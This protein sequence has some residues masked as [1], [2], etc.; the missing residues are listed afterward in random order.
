MTTVAGRAPATRSP[1]LR[2]R[3]SAHAPGLAVIVGVALVTLRRVVFT[4]G[5]PAGTDLFGF[6]SRAGQNA[7][8]ARIVD[9]WNPGSFGARRVFTF[10]NVL[11]LVTMA[12]RDPV[13]TVKLFVALTF[14]GS[15][16][17]AYALAWSWF[18][19]RPAA[20]AAGL[21]Y[22]MSQ[23]VLTR[24]G[25]GLLNVE[26]IIALA[27][28]V[29]LAW[30]ACLERFSV[31][32][33]IG[34]TLALGA[35]FLV[36]A[37]LMLYLAPF[38]VI[39]AVVVMAM[40]PGRR[41]LLANGGRTLAIAIP[42]V[43]AL[44]AAWLAPALTGQRAQYQTLSQIFSTSELSSRS[45]DLY[46]SLVG[47]GREIGY[48]GF[49]GTETWFSYPGLP[50][51]AY[52]AFAT[53]VPA[54]ALS[55]L[56]WRRDLRTVFLALSAVAAT[57]AAPGTRAPLGSVYTWLIRH[58][59]VVGNLRDPNRWLIVQALA[60]ALLAGLA[61]D[62]LAEGAPRWLAAARRRVGPSPRGEWSART[63]RVLRASSGTAL[64]LAALVPVAPTIV[65]GLRT[66]HV[67]AGQGQLLGA[68]SASAGPAGSVATVPFDQDYR[69]VV[70]GTY[71]GYEHDLGY[72]SSLYTRRGEVGDGSWNQRSANLVAY[73]ASLLD[74]GDPAFA[75]ILA[76]LGVRYLT[77]FAYPL[78]VPQLLSGSVGPYTQQAHVATMAGLTRIAARGAGS[79]YAITGASSPLSFRSSVAVVLGGS[80]GLA[81]LADWP[82]VRLSDWA[83]FSADD[84][85][86][87]QG[88][89]ALLSLIRRADLV[90]LAD[91]RPVDIAVEGTAPLATV[92][93]IT[94][95]PQLDRQAT[96]VP[97]DQSAQRGSLYDFANPVLQPGLTASSS[98]VAVARGQSAAV[99]VRVLASAQAA[100]VR[101]SVDGRAVGSVTPVTLGPGGFEWIGLGRVH[102]D[103]GRHRISLSSSPSRYGDSFEVEEARLVSPSALTANVGALDE[104][105]AASAR[106]VGYAF[107]LSDVSK[108]GWS[109]LAKR[110][111]PV[112][113]SAFSL[114][115][116]FVPRG[117]NTQESTVVSP[118]A[119]RAVQFRAVAGRTVYAV[120][121]LN[122]G[123]AQDWSHRPYVYL[124]FKG[125]GSGNTYSVYFDFGDTGATQARY[126][127]VDTSSGWRDVAFPTASPE[128]GSGPTDWS[129]VTSVRVALAS[130]SSTG[131]FALGV[132]QPSVLVHRVAVS[133]PVVPGTARFRA[134]PRPLCTGRRVPPP[135]L[136]ARTQTLE[137]SVA[138]AR[139]SCRIYAAPSGG[140]RQRP[141]TPVAV[142]STGVEKWAYSLSAPRSG[143][144]VWT[145][146][147]DPLW[148][149]DDGGASA[150]GVPVTSLA[151]GFVLGSGRH[152]GVISYGGE[153]RAVAGLAVTAGALVVLLAGLGVRSRRPR[154]E[155][156]RDGSPGDRRARR[157]RPWAVRAARVCLGLAL[158]ALVVAPLASLTGSVVLLGGLSLVVLAAA[159][160]CVLLG[161]CVAPDGVD[162]PA[163]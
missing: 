142:R 109:G 50:L 65:A 155:W 48:F 106:R 134:D 144:L 69:F 107:D 163:R 156:A 66:W 126:E 57:L 7:S 158:A 161:G 79:D 112:G 115:A 108:W 26:I 89:G 146:A 119:T 140:W 23:A 157:R 70:Q 39:Y 151:T 77:S 129:S 73:E 60:F 132:P 102:L 124:E 5:I 55:V 94:S 68:V 92:A 76:S 19:R 22:M 100:T 88:L 42:G 28:A 143:V 1:S 29:V 31:R 123:V 53:V 44:N 74:R 101:V 97:T 46:P 47:F 113:Q 125:T 117:A 38:L 153:S 152:A 49:T 118:G 150:P 18:A 84:V 96:D 85:I 135:T 83:A 149:L 11:G 43:V 160:A 36:R 15:G 61:V 139:S 2:G 154:V 145:Q 64:V 104:A 33:A 21:F 130:K 122:Y 159:A 71:Q 148:R 91:E 82:G 133:L 30:S 41:A 20:A 131:T 58:V 120:A 72:E 111:A 138:D 127:V 16:V 137:L 14:V 95:D 45:I 90:L 37:D 25:S 110:L 3:L 6:V 51:W 13:V 27:P 103:P 87:T 62:R 80:Q 93:G 40:T 32:R 34:L 12:T 86:S 54:L 162:A 35:G 98:T 99:W 78:V 56:W 9:A 17:A 121:K 81:A 10:D 8:W 116:W 24:W 136:V 4:G 67:T 105:L 114:H 59:P 128:P 52:Y 63:A 75:R 141:A 147:F